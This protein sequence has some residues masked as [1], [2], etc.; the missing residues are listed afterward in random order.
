[1][2]FHQHD[3][4]L[5]FSITT[6]TKKNKCDF[7]WLYNKLWSLLKLSAKLLKTCCKSLTEI[8]VDWYFENKK[9][10]IKKSNFYSKYYKPFVRIIMM[11]IKEMMNFNLLYLCVCLWSFWVGPEGVHDESRRC[12]ICWCPQE[13]ERRRVCQY[14]FPEHGFVYSACFHYFGSKANFFNSACTEL[15]LF[16]WHWM[17]SLNLHLLSPTNTGQ[18]KMKRTGKI[19]QCNSVLY[20]LCVLLCVFVNQISK[21]ECFFDSVSFSLHFM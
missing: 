9:C 16:Y 2:G 11:V 17:S 8:C 3:K 21:L 5:D 15:I 7:C 19:A 6:K 4:L 18:I 10:Y 14:F 20:K 1:M 12:H 13:K